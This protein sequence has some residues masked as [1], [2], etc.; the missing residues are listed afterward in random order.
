MLL[1][2]VPMFEGMYKDLGGKLPLPT[3]ILIN[4]SQLM[5]HIWWLVAIVMVGVT[6]AFRRWI[7]KPEGRL[8]WDQFKLRVPIFGP[9]MMAAPFPAW[10]AA[11]R[12]SPRTATIR[13]RWAGQMRPVVISRRSAASKRPPA[14][15]L[16]A[17]PTALTRCVVVPE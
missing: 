13:G 14:M 11:I 9:L 3:Q 7:A 8:R 5:L 16:S 2:V 6:V 4:A 10:S 17:R 1:F 15:R 12:S